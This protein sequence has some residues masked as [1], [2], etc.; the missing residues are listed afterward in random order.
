[1][2][3]SINK[4][5]LLG[6]TVGLASVTHAYPIFSW[7]KPSKSQNPSDHFFQCPKDD[8]ACEKDVQELN[9]NLTAQQ[10][11][12]R[13]LQGKIIRDLIEKAQPKRDAP[14]QWLTYTVHASPP[15][16]LKA[17]FTYPTLIDARQ[18]HL[19]TH[20]K[21]DWLDRVFENSTSEQKDDVRTRPYGNLLV[22]WS[23]AFSKYIQEHKLPLNSGFS[24]LKLNAH[25]NAQM[26]HNFKAAACRD[27][28]TCQGLLPYTAIQKTALEKLHKEGKRSAL[29]YM[30]QHPEEFRDNR[31]TWSRFTATCAAF[32]WDR[33]QKTGTR[34][35]VATPRAVK[36]PAPV[37][38]QRHTPESESFERFS[39]F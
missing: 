10:E 19:T 33:V 39:N 38:Q 35:F 26:D 18:D 23:I 27:E 20:Y 7:F 25:G 1:M 29:E 17:T 12:L 32:F 24:T 16:K 6:L 36:E 31:S 3:V 5:A 34:N 9:K 28:F 4:L 14:G 11:Q 30:D 15:N 37:V 13:P 8:T 2:K 21:I 22:P